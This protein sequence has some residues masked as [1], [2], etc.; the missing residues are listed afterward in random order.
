[1]TQHTKLHRQHL[2][3]FNNILTAL[4]Q[5]FNSISTQHIPSNG[6][7]NYEIKKIPG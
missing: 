4:Q 3:N 6:N 7:Q 5:Q 2:D 1:M